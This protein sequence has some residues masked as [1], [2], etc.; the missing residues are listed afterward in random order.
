V[1]LYLV[2]V[3]QLVIVNT[4]PFINDCSEE[5]LQAQLKKMLQSES[6][7]RSRRLRRFLRFCVEQTLLD[8]TENLK[9]YSIGLEVFEKPESFDPRMDSI[10]RVVA[11]R[12]RSMVDHYYSIEGKD[13]PVLIKFRCGTYVPSFA[14]RS[15]EVD[16]QQH[17]E[18]IAV[19]SQSSPT[20]EY[21]SQQLGMPLVPISA[22]TAEELLQ[23]V[24]SGGAQLFMLSPMSS[25][26][27][28]PLPV[29]ENVNT[30]VLQEK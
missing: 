19:M 3:G 15:G 13:D 9:E 16:G 12:L 2:R 24:A 23:R 26:V 4:L 28:A 6:F 30:E 25:S 5:A 18:Q 14:M 29:V 21:V 7:A 27:M 20:V 11:R 1:K 17:Q 10:V 8:Q 22:K